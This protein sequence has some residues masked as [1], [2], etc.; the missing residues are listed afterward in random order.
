MVSLVSDASPDHVSSRMDSSYEPKT[1]SKKNPSTLSFET[2]EGFNQ[3]AEH[4]NS[5][6]D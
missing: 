6:S 4:Y 2:V 5:V 1:D 3:K